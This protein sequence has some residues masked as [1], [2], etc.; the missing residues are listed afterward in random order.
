MRRGVLIERLAVAGSALPTP[1]ATAPAHMLDDIARA[2]RETIDST[3][4]QM[5]ECE[6]KGREARECAA[7]PSDPAGELPTILQHPMRSSLAASAKPERRQWQIIAPVILISALVVVAMLMSASIAD[8]SRVRGLGWLSDKPRPRLAARAERAADPLVAS[9]DAGPDVG[10]SMSA[11]SVAPT[12][13]LTEPFRFS[14]SE[15]ALL[16]RCERMIAGGDM[17]G[18][19]L[20]LA[21]AA[22]VGSAVARF[23]LAET[24]DPNML[25]A[26]GVRDRVAD[27]GT[28]RALYAQAFAAGVDR[29]AQRIA[30]LE[31][32]RQ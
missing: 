19:R 18:A 10:A 30:A 6:A 2:L 29:A 1:A 22:S 12:V 28:A 11:R 5:A 25:A 32:E 27:V 16:E 17:Q 7:A 13:P 21:H 31:A 8:F 26:W 14:L 4:R 9:L 20:E 23:A 24:F 3:A 15:M